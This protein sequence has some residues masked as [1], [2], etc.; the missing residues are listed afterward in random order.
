MKLRV[1][2]NGV[3]PP[4]RDWERQ[5]L[6]KVGSALP[7]SLAAGFA[8][9]VREINYVQRHQGGKEINFYRMQ[10]SQANVSVAPK[11]STPS[12][13]YLLARVRVEQPEHAPV[14]CQ[15]WVV[16]GIVFSITC[17]A[18][19]GKVGANANVR[20]LD[21]YPPTAEVERRNPLLDSINGEL[22]SEYEKRV[23]DGR[24]F[25]AGVSLLEPRKLRHVSVNGLDYC[26]LGESIDKEPLLAR[27]EKSQRG[28]FFLNVEDGKVRPAAKSL[29]EL[30]NG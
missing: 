30:L 17:D 7:D 29:A 6:D 16:S 14:T 3:L 20:I 4:L 27:C 22:R 18:P 12:E 8:E 24:M 21:A 1:L 10:G 9:Q 25:G 13:E 15:L 23:A 28:L 19:T 11:I 26:V 2:L 5:L